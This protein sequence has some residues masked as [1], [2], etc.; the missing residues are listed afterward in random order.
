MH[1]SRIFRNKFKIVF[2]LD[3]QGIHI[4]ADG[5]HPAGFLADQPGHDARFR[6]PGKL[7]IAERLKL[8]V[9]ELGGFFLLEG[10]FRMGMQ[11]APP[12]DHFL[13]HFIDEPFDLFI[14]HES[15]PLSS[16]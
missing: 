11:M 12:A 5:D 14:R 8:F 6:R 9:D 13:L 16:P 7:K 15:P 3:R 4:G 10:K 1:H 2:L